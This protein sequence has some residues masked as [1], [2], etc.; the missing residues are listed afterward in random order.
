MYSRLHLACMLISSI[1]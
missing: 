1:K